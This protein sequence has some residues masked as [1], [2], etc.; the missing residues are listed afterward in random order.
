MLPTYVCCRTLKM[1]CEYECVYYVV[2]IMLYTH[3]LAPKHTHIHTR[4]HT[5]NFLF[6]I[7]KRILVFKATLDHRVRIVS[8]FFLSPPPPPKEFPRSLFFFPRHFFLFLFLF[9]FV[10]DRKNFPKAFLSVILKSKCTKTLT[11]VLLSVT[12]CYYVLL[13]LWFCKASVLRHSLTFWH[14]WFSVRESVRV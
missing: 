7:L 1:S 12:M 10:Q 6:W 11:L 13:H 3:T 5:R 14:T 4:T 2:H 8:R 9:S